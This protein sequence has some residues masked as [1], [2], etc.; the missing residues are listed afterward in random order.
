[1][2]FNDI[3]DMFAN[4]NLNV[5]DSIETL[6]TL[7]QKIVSPIKSLSQGF[8]L[9][10]VGIYLSCLLAYIDRQSFVA[11]HKFIIYLENWLSSCTDSKQK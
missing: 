2:S 7:Q 3:V 6:S 8:V 1:M 4:L 11:E 10:F 5:N 9:A